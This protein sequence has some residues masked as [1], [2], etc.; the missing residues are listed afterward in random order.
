MADQFVYRSITPEDADQVRQLYYD[1]WRSEPLA[2]S[3]KIQVPRECEAYVNYA[4]AEAVHNK[5]SVAVEEKAT[6]KIVGI[7]MCVIA[8][9]ENPQ[10]WTFPDSDPN[11]QKLRKDDE[12]LHHLAITKDY[13]KHYGVD[14]ILESRGMTVNK[15]YGR[16][17]IGIKMFEK[18]LEIARHL[19]VQLAV[20]DCTS[21]HSRRIFD[22]LGFE[23]VNEIDLRDYRELGPLEIADDS[24]HWQGTLHVLRLV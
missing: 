9:P 18:T 10:I 17:G 4:L 15:N 5:V 1:F 14:K 23:K 24:P 13:F 21:A 20:I 12:I 22:K 11:C 6:G 16:R 3:L 8:T 7:N 2:V 19:G